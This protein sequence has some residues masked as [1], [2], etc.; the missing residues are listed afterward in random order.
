MELCEFGRAGKDPTKLMALIG[1]VERL[2]ETKEQSVKKA[3]RS[4]AEN[5]AKNA[6]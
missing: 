6:R 1:E 4:V 5:P 2:L 3:P